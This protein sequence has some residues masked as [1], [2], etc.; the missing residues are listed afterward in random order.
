L[1]SDA[2]TVRIARGDAPRLDTI[3]VASVSAERDEI[4]LMSIPRDTVD[5]PMPDGST[6]AEKINAIYAFR[7]IDAMRGAVETLLDISIDHYVLLDMDDFARLIDAVGGIAVN[8]P[9]PMQ[10][11]K[12][13]LSIA[14][15]PQ[16]MSGETALKYAR[17]RSLDG[18]Y[19][20]AARQQDMVLALARAIADP[21]RSVEPA[22]VLAALASLKTDLDLAELPGALEVVRAS[23][24]ATVVKVVLKP[25][26]FAIF[27]GIAGS[28]GWVMFPNVAEMRAFAA[29]ALAD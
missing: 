7:G 24:S 1:G 17:S 21:A 13:R 12:V 28:R 25:P 27:E 16:L 14:A 18:D 5:V 2:D 20:R 6:W 19:G 4:T 9:F 26:R 23:G 29:E 10:D 11:R 8:V 22:A 15:G 3:I